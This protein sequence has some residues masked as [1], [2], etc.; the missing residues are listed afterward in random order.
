MAGWVAGNM[1]GWGR[2]PKYGEFGRL[3]PHLR[4]AD[5]TARKLAR[6]LAFQMAR[7]GPKLE[8]RQ[9]ILFRLV[10]VGAEIFAIAATCGRAQELVRRNPADEGPLVM[11]DLFCRGARRRIAESF[12]AIAK[13]DDVFRYR[14]AQQ[15]LSGEHTWLE[16]GVVDLTTATV[17]QGE[18][19][20]VS[21]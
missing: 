13:N 1:V 11:A 20:E 18:A 2:W 10:D 21:A 14:V 17:K 4:Y 15:V 19:V 9:S 8:K 5:R 16:A 6:T 3:A 7:L 12:R